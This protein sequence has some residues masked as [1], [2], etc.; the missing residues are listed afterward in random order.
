[1]N[2]KLQLKDIL[3]YLEITAN[4]VLYQK[5]LYTT[6]SPVFEDEDYEVF[7]GYVMDIPWIYLDF[8]LCEA[9]AEGEAISL[10]REQK[11]D[12]TKLGFYILI[13]QKEG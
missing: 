5:D 8:Y 4:V 12:K 1:M 6:D 13:Q 7:E 10:F 11:D 2:K 3:P 9:D